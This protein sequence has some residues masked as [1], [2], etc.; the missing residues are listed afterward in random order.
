M[1]VL[2]I[3]YYWPPAGGPG[4][5]RWLKFVKYFSHFGVEPIVYVPENPTYPLKD[6]SLHTEL[7]DTIKV[8]KHPIVEPYRFA[9]VFAKKETKTISKGII[10]NQEQQSFIQ[11]LLLYVRG[12]FFI[13]DARKF[14]VSPSVRYLTTF[15]SE[16][17]VDAI[18]T[19]GPPHS[20]HLI[21]QQLKEKI[22]IPWI[23]DFR[24]PWTTIGYHTQLK[25]TKGSQQKHLSLEQAVLDTTDH[26]LVTSHT[27]KVQFEAKT[28]TPI[29][30][31][32]NGYDIEKEHPSILD[33]NFT[34][35]H[36]GSLLSGRNPL[37]LWKVLQD[38]T[39]EYPDFS[40][41]FRLKLVGAVSTDVL[42]HIYASGLK[43]YVDLVGYIS[44]DEAIQLQRSSQVV[45]LI[46]IDS[47]DTRCIIPGK[48]FEYM[49]SKRP[50]LA[51]G[52]KD[53]DVAKIIEETDSGHFFEY[54]EYERMKTQITN[55]F[56]AFQE[57]ELVSQSK[58]I[59][60]YSRESL[61]RELTKVLNAVVLNT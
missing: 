3:T 60:K 33:T 28:N 35:A 10:A 1:K 31:I 55:H 30:V 29:S 26:I 57:K 37:Q 43:P 32:T 41:W 47:P 8:I 27:T 39:V 45:L 46:E 16:N 42:E 11:R 48:V 2:I 18:I 50:I 12:N 34:I 6:A 9:Q 53:A 19:T 52:P 44:H 20:V 58:G 14:W 5:Q 56:K 21:G 51:L 38:L 15:L 4:V 22:N 23:A 25:L 7:P 24:D 36:I 13:P 59:E 54:H 49:A 61:T 40:K 17:P